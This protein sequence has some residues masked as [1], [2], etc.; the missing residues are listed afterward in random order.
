MT[1]N[2]LRIVGVDGG[3]VAAGREGRTVLVA[4]LLEGSRIVDLRLGKVEIDGLDA[5]RTLLSLLKP[6]R[7]DVVMLS[8]VAFAGFNV[9]DIKRLARSIR[10]PV[11]AII[12]EKPN[13]TAVRIALQKHFDD[14]SAR[15]KA[16]KDAGRIYSCKPVPDEPRIYFE[17]SGG[18][19]AL[20]R[21]V[22]VST[23]C[24]S[25]LPEP[26]RVAGA[27]ARGLRGL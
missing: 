12:R 22:I 13:N 2:P 25:R 23:A 16:V 26:V 18:S 5:G 6:L 3:S 9:V 17:V 27:I 14:W 10:K 21:R 19:A 11:I 7:F 1:R 15:W 4:V 20:A 8:S 24:I